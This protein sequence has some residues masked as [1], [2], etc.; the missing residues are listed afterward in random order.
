MGNVKYWVY[1]VL[2]FNLLASFFMLKS[3]N[4]ILFGIEI[5]F[6]LF[7]LLGSILIIFGFENQKSF[8]FSFGLIFFTFSVCNSLIL[9]FHTNIDSFIF[10]S[11][12]G[13]FGAY[14][15]LIF[16]PVNHNRDVPSKY[17]YE[18]T[19]SKKVVLK[20]ELD[21]IEKDFSE[22]LIIEEIT[23]TAKKTAKKNLI[24]ENI[25]ASK[26]SVLY[27]KS[28]CPR[29]KAIPSKN[30]LNFKSRF[31]AEQHGFSPHDCLD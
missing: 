28:S 26:K 16:V 29:A 11:L 6:T 15:T 30:K 31:D 27:H 23:S 10:I 13:V 14:L 17:E 4:G 22:E 2:F 24:K 9:F 12:F 7:I 21:S 18:S 19:N 20:H 3:F 1:L 25:I 8:L 5:I